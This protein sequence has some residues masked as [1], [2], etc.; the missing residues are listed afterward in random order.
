MSGYFYIEIGV[1]LLLGWVIVWLTLPFEQ[2]YD[3]SLRA[4]SREPIF[5]ILLGLLLMLVS[6]YSVPVALLTFLIL[7]FWIADIHLVSTVKF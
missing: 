5:R 7:F 2:H 4:Y 6:A 1:I 3:E